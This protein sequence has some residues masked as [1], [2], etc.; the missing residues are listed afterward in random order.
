ML[1]D[2]YYYYL[3]VCAVQLM[4]YNFKNK[5]NDLKQLMHTFNSEVYFQK[6]KQ[7]I[8]VGLRIIIKIYT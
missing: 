4:Q 6:S 7:T 3:I 1:Y 5:Y 2:A 8:F